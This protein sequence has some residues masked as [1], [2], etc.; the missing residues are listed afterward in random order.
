MVNRARLQV[1]IDGA[2]N[3]LALLARLVKEH[4]NTRQLQIGVL[5]D[6]LLLSEGD[7]RTPS[8]F[9]PCSFRIVSQK[10]LAI[11]LPA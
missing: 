5:A 6:V 4:I 9:R 1:D 10:A 3:I 2:R 8:L 11:W 7:T